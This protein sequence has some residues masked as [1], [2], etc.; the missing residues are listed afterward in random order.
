MTLE[1]D[2]QFVEAKEAGKRSASRLLDTHSVEEA[3]SYK[4]T[5]QVTVKESQELCSYCGKTGH[6]KKS[7]AQVC[8]TRCTAYG[9]KCYFVIEITILSVYAEARTIPNAFSASSGKDI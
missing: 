8:R 9:H 5:K 4:K 1:D 6:G 7:L 3:N 2:F